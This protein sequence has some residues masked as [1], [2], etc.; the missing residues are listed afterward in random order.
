MSVVD[1][2]PRGK[3]TGVS[4]WYGVY[5]KSVVPKMEEAA[6]AGRYALQFLLAEVHVRFVEV[7]EPFSVERE[8]ANVNTLGDYKKILDMMSGE[9]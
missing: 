3:A 1:N 2:T 8:F 6:R 7:T 5:A 9:K 4:P